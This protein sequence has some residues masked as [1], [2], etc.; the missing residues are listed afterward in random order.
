MLLLPED[1]LPTA[2]NNGKIIGLDVITTVGQAIPRRP[3]GN[4]ITSLQNGS[5]APRTKK[6]AREILLQQKNQASSE[7]SPFNKEQMEMLQKLLQESVQTALNPIGTATIA[8]RG[9][10]LTA[11]IAKRGSSKPWIVDSGESDHMTR[12]ATVFNNYSPSNDNTVVRIADGTSS[13][14]AGIGSAVISM[15][16][17]LNSVLFVPKLDCNLLSISKLTNDLNC[18]T[19]F[20]PNVC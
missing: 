6:T 3:A 10:Y 9:N 13:R 12:D 2:I 17:T 16:I 7:P 20:L 5:L 19:K 18:V 8:Q 1:H 15:D 14:V 4:S 11:L